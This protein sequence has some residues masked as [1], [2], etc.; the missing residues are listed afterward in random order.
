MSDP[1]AALLNKTLAKLPPNAEV[2]ASHGVVGAFAERLYLYQVDQ[3]AIPINRRHTYF[4]VA[5]SQ[6]INVE[7]VKDE[8]ARDL[9]VGWTAH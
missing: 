3:G 2:V 5:P 4:I 1:A 8:L 9:M 7:S 6:G